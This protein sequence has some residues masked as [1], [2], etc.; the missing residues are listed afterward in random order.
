MSIGRPA[1]QASYGSAS[2]ATREELSA[3]RARN[4]A[5]E[6]K[7]RAR[8]GA[9]VVSHARVGGLVSDTSNNACAAVW[10][11]GGYLSDAPV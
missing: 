8:L 4:M 5:L 2:T 1:S 7:V 3:L 6:M 10:G 9:L 11:L